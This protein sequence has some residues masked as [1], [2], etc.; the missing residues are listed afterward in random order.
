[1]SSARGP[2]LP[3]DAPDPLTCGPTAM[4]RAIAPLGGDADLDETLASG[5]VTATHQK[6]N[7]SRSADRQKAGVQ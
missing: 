4:T 6:H 5:L 7:E 2:Q 1:V 3:L